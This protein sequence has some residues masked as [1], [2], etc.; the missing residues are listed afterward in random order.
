MVGVLLVLGI[1]TFRRFEQR[2]PLWHRLLKAFGV[3]AVTAVV[4][5][6]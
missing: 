4:S 5:H 3:P 2:M 6:G 1:V